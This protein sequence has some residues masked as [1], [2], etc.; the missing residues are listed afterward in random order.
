GTIV[1]VKRDQD[2]YRKRKQSLIFFE[3][4]VLIVPMELLTSLVSVCR[5]ISIIA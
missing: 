1:I 4:Y 2:C 3:Y 5:F